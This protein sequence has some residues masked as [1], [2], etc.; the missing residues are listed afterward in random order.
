MMEIVLESETPT[1]DF[2]DAK[3]GTRNEERGTSNEGHLELEGS[4]SFRYLVTVSVQSAFKSIWKTLHAPLVLLPVKP[5]SF[6]LSMAWM[7]SFVSNDL[8]Y[9][10]RY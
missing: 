4:E 3:R 6:N 8:F 1:R 2:V 9:T 7:P 5:N 10:L